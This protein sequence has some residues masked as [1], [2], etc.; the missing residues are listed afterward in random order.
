MEAGGKGTGGKLK[1][2]AAAM[3]FHYSNN[4]YD[5]LYDENIDEDEK[6]IE[7]NDSNKRV[8]VGCG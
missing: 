8:K 7:N 1:E 4:N 3:L 5:H 6:R 2:R